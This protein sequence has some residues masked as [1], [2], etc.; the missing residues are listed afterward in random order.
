MP[1]EAP[2]P[3]DARR[4]GAS[5]DG[6]GTG[7]AVFSTAGRYGG[8]GS[9]SLVDASGGGGG[10]PMWPEQDVWTCYVPGVG[11]GQAYG[12][13]ATGPNDPGRGLRFDASRLLL[14]PYARAMSPSPDGG[15]RALH[16]RVVDTT[17]DWKGDRP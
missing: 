6:S 7:F 9:P 8:A 4:L 16:S 17:F 5:W 2:R 1:T 11:P 3:G 12:F 13:R 15:A 14:D 10:L